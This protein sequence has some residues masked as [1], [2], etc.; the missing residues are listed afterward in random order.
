MNDDPII[1]NVARTSPRV[2]N[3]HLANCLR[4]DGLSIGLDFRRFYQRFKRSEDGELRLRTGPGV[5]RSQGRF[6]IDFRCG[7]ALQNLRFQLRGK[8]E[9]V[10]DRYFSQDV[11]ECVVCQ[12][13]VDLSP[14]LRTFDSAVVRFR[15]FGFVRVRIFTRIRLRFVR[16]L[17]L[18]DLCAWVG[19]LVVLPF[20]RR[21][22][23]NFTSGG[24]V[25]HHARLRKYWCGG[26]G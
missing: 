20:G 3:V 25:Y 12:D 4:E 1:A 11:V 7:L 13:G 19:R 9:D 8:V 21:E 2:V 18:D 22:G 14:P 15:E 17:A 5:V 10:N 24:H 23:P 16:R 6:L 26:G